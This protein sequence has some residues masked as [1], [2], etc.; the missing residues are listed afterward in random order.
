MAADPSVVHFGAHSLLE[1]LHA[2]VRETDGVRQAQDLEYVHR[3]RVASRRLRQ[4]L[5]LFTTI[6]PERRADPWGKE[7]KRLTR[8]LGQARD[9]DV[10]IALLEQLESELSDAKTNPG[11]QRLLLRLR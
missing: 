8:A 3:M 6:L 4:R 7:V 9:R 5:T 10:Q 11:Y 1:E 2:L